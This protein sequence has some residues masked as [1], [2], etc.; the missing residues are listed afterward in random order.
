VLQTSPLAFSALFKNKHFHPVILL[1]TSYQVFD[2]KEGGEPVLDSVNQYGIGKYNERRRDMYD[3]ELFNVEGKIRD[4]HVG[5]DISAP[6][7][8][9]VYAFDQGFI[10]R[11]AINSQ[12]GD[13][14][15]TILTEHEIEG[16]RYWI[17]FGHLSHRSVVQAEIG[18]PFKMGDV[19]AWIGDRNENGGW[20]SHLHLQMSRSLPAH[21]DLPG[22]VSEADLTWALDEFP[23]PRLI[24]GDLY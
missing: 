17:L 2:L 7:E 20:N 13:F 1:P 16:V 5:V 24:L 22:V 12:K 19:I 23:D 6:A 14:G 11:K 8:T 10:L 9:A 3:H 4:V 18:R 21:C 15:G